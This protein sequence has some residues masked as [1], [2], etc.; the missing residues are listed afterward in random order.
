MSNKEHNRL[1]KREKDR[2]EK[3]HKIKD[4]LTV[5]NAA[6]LSSMNNSSSVVLKFNRHFNSSNVG[7]LRSNGNDLLH[8]KSNE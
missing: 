4:A 6:E 8:N 3:V 5:N 2:R 1:L 7:P